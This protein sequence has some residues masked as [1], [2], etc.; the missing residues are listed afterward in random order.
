MNSKIISKILTEI[1]DCNKNIDNVLLHI[2]YE[3][4]KKAYNCIFNSEKPRDI[5]ALLT[6]CS[7]YLKSCSVIINYMHSIPNQDIY[8]DIVKMLDQL[9]KLSY[10]K[11]KFNGLIEKEIFEKK[12]YKIY[13]NAKWILSKLRDLKIKSQR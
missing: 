3:L 8:N 10:E 9:I 12:Y 13:H 4:V 5:S 2:L 1:E 6:A 7:T 11:S